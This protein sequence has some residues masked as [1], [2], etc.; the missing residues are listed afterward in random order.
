MKKTKKP[1]AVA[2]IN[3]AHEGLLKASAERV[4]RVANLEKRIANLTTEREAL[5]SQVKAL[6]GEVRDIPPVTPDNPAYWML[7]ALRFGEN[8]RRLTQDI[9]RLRSLVP[10]YYL[11]AEMDTRRAA[12]KAKT[13]AA[14]SRCKIWHTWEELQPISPDDGVWCLLCCQLEY[15]GFSSSREERYAVSQP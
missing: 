11:D 14:C 12:A 2:R 9:E 8:I 5:L 4:H 15:D 10:D 13:G 3:A 1:S 7:T 6:T